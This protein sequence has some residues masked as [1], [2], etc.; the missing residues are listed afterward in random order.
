MQR[1]DSGSKDKNAKGWFSWF[2]KSN[3]TKSDETIKQSDSDKQE[4]KEKKEPSSKQSTSTVSLS[5]IKSFFPSNNQDEI[6]VEIPPKEM[7]DELYTKLS[8]ATELKNKAV[9]KFWRSQVTF[10]GGEEMTNGKGENCGVVPKGVANMIVAT[11]QALKT[12]EK[13]SS[14]DML[15][16][17]KKCTNVALTRTSCVTGMYRKKSVEDFY[18]ILET[19]NFDDKNKVEWALARFQRWE[20]DYDANKL[21]VSDKKLKK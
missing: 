6:K 20:E 4:S 3:E 13:L 19:V 15:E 9:I 5:I 7:I 12:S 10:P 18:K 8:D 17:M 16:I 14:R 11:D 1:N 21:T 2:Y